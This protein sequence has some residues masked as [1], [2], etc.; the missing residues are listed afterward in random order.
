M[1]LNYLCEFVVLAERRSYALAADELFLSESSLSRHIKKLEEEL[2]FP[3]FRRSTRRVELTEFGAALLGSA[4]RAEELQN[5]IDRLTAEYRKADRSVLTISAIETFA[6]YLPSTEWLPA[7][8]NENPDIML[9]ISTPNAPAGK[10]LQDSAS[11]VCFAPELAG[12]EDPDLR[13][14]T[15]YHDRMVAILSAEHPLAGQS[16][17]SLAD[18]KHEHLVL[19]AKNSPM[20]EVCT[21]ACGE[22]GFRPFVRITADGKYIKEL[23]R[24]GFGIGIL[25]AYASHSNMD[26]TLVCRPLEPVVPVDLNILYSGDASTSVRKYISFMKRYLNE[27]NSIEKEGNQR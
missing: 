23:V 8:Q 25:L 13:R 12:F 27:H 7:F 16:K 15:V 5:E 4:R 1:Q 19:L 26:E 18:L 2:G 3:L 24:R 10:T 22:Y 6:H 11:T 17:L 14:L 9:Q 21:R 20:Y